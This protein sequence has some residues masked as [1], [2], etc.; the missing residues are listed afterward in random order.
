MALEKGIRVESRIDADDIEREYFGF[1]SQMK[2][3]ERKKYL[4]RRKNFGIFA[5]EIL[6]VNKEINNKV[7]GETA[8]LRKKIWSI[9]RERYKE[10]K[11][12]KNKRFSM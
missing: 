7:R 6:G 2:L 9:I 1:P 3:E 12:K 11:N 5:Q 4:A 10:L 8:I